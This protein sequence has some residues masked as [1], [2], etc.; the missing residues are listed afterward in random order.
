VLSLVFGIASWVALP[1]LGAVVAV[2]CG[3]IARAEIR[4]AAPGT[5]QGEG[6]ALAGLILGYVHL[7]LILLFALGVVLVLAGL[8]AYHH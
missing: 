7:A 4:R 6:M 5:V 1:F 3:H 8:V 2:V